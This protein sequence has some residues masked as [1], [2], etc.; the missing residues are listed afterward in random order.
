M[1]EAVQQGELPGFYFLQ[2]EIAS[3]SPPRSG[4][5]GRGE[6]ARIKTPLPVPLPAQ[7]RGEGMIWRVRNLL[8]I[9][10]FAF[11]PSA[12]VKRPVAP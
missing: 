10:S 2:Y 4:G 11:P 5:E 6:V 9:P 12:I 3:P 1:L 7:L 8:L